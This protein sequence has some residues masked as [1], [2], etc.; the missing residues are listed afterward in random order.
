MTRGQVDTDAPPQPVRRVSIPKPGGGERPLGIPTIRDWVAI[1]RLMTPLGMRY[2]DAYATA[3]PFDR[4]VE[5]M[6]QPE[7][8]LESVEIVKGAIEKGVL[9]NLIINN[10]ADGNAPM[11]ARE[12]ATKFLE[13]PKSKTPRQLNLWD[14]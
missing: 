2:E 10:R 9:T 6:L 1:I 12:I 7:M 11:I 13:K 3:H 14:T 4:L 5:D 8:I